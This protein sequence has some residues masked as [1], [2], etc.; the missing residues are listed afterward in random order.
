VAVTALGVGFAP[1]LVSLF[2]GGYARIPGELERTVLL[3]RWVFPYILCMGT[4]ALL[5]GML[6]VVAQW[7]SLNAI[8][9][10]TRPSFAL[11]NPG[12]REVGRRMAP[13]LVGM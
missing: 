5:G 11:A 10:F 13:L 3:T 6:H 2:A 8:W 4:A 1:T 12:V 7:C 9:Y